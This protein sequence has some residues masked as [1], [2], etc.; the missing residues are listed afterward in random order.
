MAFKKREPITDIEAL[1]I[2][3]ISP[4]S[5]NVFRQC[6]RRWF[7]QYV[8]AIETET[9]DAM[10]R[11]NV[12]HHVL[13]NIFNITKFPS[14]E[15]FRT[16]IMDHAMSLFEKEW[17]DFFDSKKHELY[18]DSKLMVTRFVNKFVDNI[19]NGINN[20]EY[21]G[22]RHGFYMTRPKFRE[23]WLDDQFKKDDN[24][25]YLL[26]ENKEKI[27]LE[28]SLNV[29]GFIDSVEKNFAFEKILIDYKTSKKYKNALSEEYVLQLSIYA[30]LWSV[31]KNEMPSY[32]AINYLKYDETFYIQVTPSL[33]EMAKKKIKHMRSDMIENGLD[34]DK[35]ECIVGKLCNWCSFQDKCGKFDSEEK[36]DEK[37]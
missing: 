25:R 7:Y 35:Y 28:N 19:Q 1:K 30:Y 5:I 33:I 15:R 14:G 37:K 4:S 9:T 22:E 12:V 24:N 3:R 32:V 11:G 27:P 10:R 6:P 13:E 18:N 31:N 16:A 23:L 34:E 29:G 26:D 17:S 36:K 8:Q 2:L 21:Q 20:G